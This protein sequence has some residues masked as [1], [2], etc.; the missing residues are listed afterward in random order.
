MK[1]VGIP[2]HKPYFANILIS[3]LGPQAKREHKSGGEKR[4]QKNR[5]F[6]RI[7]EFIGRRD[8]SGAN[9]ELLIEE[10]KQPGEHEVIQR[11]ESIGLDEQMRMIQSVNAHAEQFVFPGIAKDPSWNKGF[12]LMSHIFVTQMDEPVYRGN[13]EIFFQDTVTGERKIEFLAGLIRFPGERWRVFQMK[14]VISE[15]N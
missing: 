11:I 8:A 2:T 7:R 5:I 1:V 3:V 6:T 9:L 14:G 4:M 12:A 10:P 15:H 13:I